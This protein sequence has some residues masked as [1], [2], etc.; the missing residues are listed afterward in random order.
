MEEWGAP[1]PKLKHTADVAALALMVAAIIYLLAFAAFGLYL[2]EL[3]KKDAGRVKRS[4]SL[5]ELKNA[6]KI[7]V[8]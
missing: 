5:R 3:P 8:G 6:A 7:I 4:A 2:D 1:L